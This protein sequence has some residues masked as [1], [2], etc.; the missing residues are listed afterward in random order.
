MF[1][2]QVKP[3]IIYSY[4]IKTKYYYSFS[5]YIYIKS[6]LNIRHDDFGVLADGCTFK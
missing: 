3:S 5:V 4:T 2:S 1:L 6:E